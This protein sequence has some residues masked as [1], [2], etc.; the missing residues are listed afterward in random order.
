MLAVAVVGC[1]PTKEQAE[2]Q[3]SKSA[4]VYENIM[5]RR[6]VRAYKPE[7]VDKAQL[8][9]IITCAINAPSAQNKQSWEVRVVQSEE[10]LNKFKAADERFGFGAPTVIFVAEQKDAMFSPVDCGLLAQNILLMAESMDLGTVVIGGIR[11]NLDSPAMQEALAAIEIPE[12]HQLSF[13]ITLGYKDQRPDAKP[14]DTSK[15]KFF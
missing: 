6:S 4:V 10:V 2:P 7:Q 12:T 13:A 11:R 14:R 3:Q 8:D 9:S 5:N 1:C 15:V